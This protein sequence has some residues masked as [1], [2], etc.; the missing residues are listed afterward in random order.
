[1]EDANN[2]PE[3]SKRYFLDQMLNHETVRDS[4][5]SKQRGAVEVCIGSGVRI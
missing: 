2:L 5:A 1:M 3:E 4:Q